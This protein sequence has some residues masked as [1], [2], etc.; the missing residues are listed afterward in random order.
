MLALHSLV[1]I[2]K[3]QPNGNIYNPNRG[4]F[5]NGFYGTIFSLERSLM[6]EKS[7]NHA[8]FC[9]VKITPGISAFSLL[10]C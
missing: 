5:K 9:R 10:N 2:T 4:L 3:F 1:R 8:H 6:N 7:P